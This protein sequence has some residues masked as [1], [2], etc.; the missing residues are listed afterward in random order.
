MGL[1][2]TLSSATGP[3]KNAGTPTRNSLRRS[4]E[5]RRGIVGVTAGH[6]HRTIADQQALAQPGAPRVSPVALTLQRLQDGEGS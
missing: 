6:M 4:G 2:V 3:L 1:R 5:T